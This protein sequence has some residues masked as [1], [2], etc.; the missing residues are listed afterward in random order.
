MQFL[1]EFEIV[2]IGRP[3][4]GEIAAVDD[5]IGT[6]R[7][8]VLADAMKISVSLVRRRARWVSEIWVRRNWSCNNP[9][10]AIIHCPYMA[11]KSER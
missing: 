9:F 5:E 6:R 11:L 8:D 2:A 10:I 4:E 3:V 7:V 1:G